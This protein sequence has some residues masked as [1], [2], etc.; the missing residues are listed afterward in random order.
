MK[1]YLFHRRSVVAVLLGLAVL[2]CAKLGYSEPNAP[3]NGLDF[4]GK[5]VLLY[6]EGRPADETVII[7]KAEFRT[8]SGKTLLVGFEVTQ[9]AHNWANGLKHAVSWD[10][11]AHFYVI[12]SLE[13]FKR[14]M[15]DRPSQQIKY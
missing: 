4:S 3:E 15:E 13:D 10:R 11:V 1:T 12:D 9:D 5:L 8:V 14:R 2:V 6:L 7:E